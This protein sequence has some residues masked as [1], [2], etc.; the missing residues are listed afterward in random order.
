MNEMNGLGVAADDLVTTRDDVHR[1]P[2]G[3]VVTGLIAM[4][5]AMAATTVTAA[6]ARA[7]RS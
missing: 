3:L 6:L 4:L 1:R 5:V 2:K 7:R